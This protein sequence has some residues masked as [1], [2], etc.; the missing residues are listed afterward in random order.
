[1]SLVKF[2]FVFL[3]LCSFAHADIGKR[4]DR[5]AIKGGF[6]LSY[7]DISRGVQEEKFFT[8]AINT[9]LSWYQGRFEFT[10]NALLSFGKIDEITHEIDDKVFAGEGKVFD[11]SISP[12]IKYELP[13]ALKSG[14]WP[15]Y[16][17][18]GP[19]WSLYTLRFRDNQ[20]L[21]AGFEVSSDRYK[22][23]YDTV[24]YNIVLGAEELTRYKDMHP[25]YI[26]LIY[27]YRK[28][29][30]ISLV[31]TEKFLEADIVEFRRSH[32]RLEYHSIMLI[33]GVTFF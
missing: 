32:K 8:P 27:S 25:V 3:L 13:Y 33:M 24:G 17:G 16:I 21:D 2:S 22:L 11:L 15:T 10:A 12:I 20:A 5:L 7:V 1:M 29:R 26:E 23:T 14:L 9:Q 31:D 6:G 30:K 28:S 19:A 4:L 18:A